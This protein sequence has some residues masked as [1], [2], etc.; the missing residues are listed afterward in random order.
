MCLDEPDEIIDFCKER[1]YIPVLITVPMSSE[2]SKRFSEEF[3][4]EMIIDFVDGLT[5]KDVKF[6]DY[7]IDETFQDDDLFNGSM[8]FNLRGRKRFT[9]QVVRDLNV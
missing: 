8:C 4:Q 9:N 2:L 1:E 7:F 6:L 5:N 3:H